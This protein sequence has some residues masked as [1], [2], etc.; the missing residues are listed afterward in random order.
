MNGSLDKLDIYFKEVD[1]TKLDSLKRPVYSVTDYIKNIKMAGEA[2]DAV[3]RFRAQML[4]E[5]RNQVTA[6]NNTVL[7]K[8]EEEYAFNNRKSTPW[9]EASP[10]H[11]PELEEDLTDDEEDPE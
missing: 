6:R 8:R 11:A 10:H 3:K 9:T 4:E 5:L 7:G 1:F 2:H